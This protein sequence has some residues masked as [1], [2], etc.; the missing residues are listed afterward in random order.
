MTRLARSAPEKPGVPRATTSRST[1]GPR[2]LPLAWTARIALALDQVGQR[3]LDRA[4]EAARSEQRRV[5][6]LRAG[7]SR[8]SRR[9]RWPGSKP[10]ISAS[11]WLRVCSRSSLPPN[12]LPRLP[13]IASISS[14]KMIAGARF[15]GVGEQVP[16]PRCAD[17]DEHLDEARAG[18][19][20]ERH[21]GLAG[22]RAGHQ[23]LAG[24]GR[25]DHQHALR[26]DRA[27]LGVALRVL[28]EVDDLGDLAL[29][30]LIAGDVGEPGGRTFLVVDLR[31][32]AR[33]SPS[34][35]RRCRRRPAASWP[36]G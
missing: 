17:A 8:R 6:G 26:P 28:Q 20:E 19:G 35:G 23:R 2:C 14:M 31:L 5:E 15:A 18:Q 36:A 1:S 30:A 21:L 33:R 12:A 13:P 10:S 3:D 34:V 7:W 4:V 25:A 9:R 24:S 16:D 11:I 27:G 32:G 29:G 22:D